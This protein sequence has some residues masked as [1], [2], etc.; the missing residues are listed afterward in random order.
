MLTQTI[1]L[2]KCDWKVKVYYAVDR[3]YLEDILYDLDNLNIDNYEYLQIK[4]LM[5]SNEVNIGFTYTDYRQ[6]KSIIVIGLTTSAAEFQNTFDHEK[7]HLSMHICQYYH[8]NPYDEEFQYLTG[9]IGKKL[10]PYAKQFLCDC[11]RE[12]FTLYN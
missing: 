2:S 9:E 8:L 1:Y 6:K 4:Q 11:C 5:E 7:G 10:F 12:G 3:Y